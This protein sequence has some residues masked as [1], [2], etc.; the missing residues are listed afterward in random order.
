GNLPKAY[1]LYMRTARLDLDDFNNEV[2]DG[3]HITS[4]AGTWLSVVEGFGGMRIRNDKVLLRP[5]I[6]DKWD[7]YSFHARF[8]GILFEVLVSRENVK[9]KNYSRDDLNL[10]FHDEDYTVPAG[11]TKSLK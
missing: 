4:M 5:L 3:L 11:K 9:I 8:R 7:S 10:I 1:D 2:A 6:P